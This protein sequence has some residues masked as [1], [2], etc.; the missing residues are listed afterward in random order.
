MSEL[1]RWKT[2]SGTIV[3]EAD[4]E[5]AGYASVVRR[6]GEIV[7]DVKNRFEES[8][9]S[10][11]DAAASALKVFRDDTLRPDEVAIE[12]GLK[13]NAEVGVVMAKAA[14]EGHLVVK[15]RWARGDAAVPGE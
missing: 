14:A 15:L 11:R 5:Q 6:P 1:L 8:L 12:F 2:E 9:E 10:F 3:V 13:L 7:S 4:E